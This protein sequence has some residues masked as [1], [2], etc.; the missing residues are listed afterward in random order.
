MLLKTPIAVAN[1]KY[2]NKNCAHIFEQIDMLPYPLSIVVCAAALFY[3]LSNEIENVM[4][5]KK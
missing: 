3:F 1:R 2:L 4:L 5:Q